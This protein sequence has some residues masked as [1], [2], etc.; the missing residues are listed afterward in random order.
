MSDF[1]KPAVLVLELKH[2]F[3]P[4][5]DQLEHIDIDRL[6]IEV[7]GAEC[8]RPQRVFAGFVAGRDDDFCSRRNRENLGQRRQ[9]LGGSVRIGRQAEIDDG[10]RNR[11][12]FDKIDRFLARS[13]REYLMIRKGP[14][15]L[16][17]QPRII[18][19]EQQGF[20]IG[21]HSFRSRRRIS[22]ALSLRPG[23][24]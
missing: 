9:P 8:D 22:P 12:P 16:A 1:G 2:S 3:C 19:D 23:V 4:A 7:I 18:V 20:W 6:L 10:Y 11:F 15:Q 14:A 24:R 5:D 13:G 21:G 17:Q